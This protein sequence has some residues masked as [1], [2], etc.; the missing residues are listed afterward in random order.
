MP[1]TVWLSNLSEIDD[2]QGRFSIP[3]L[4]SPLKEPFSDIL[5]GYK[6]ELLG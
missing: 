6:K 4:A 2:F 3:A 5:V 1:G